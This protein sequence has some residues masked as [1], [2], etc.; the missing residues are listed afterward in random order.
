MIYYHKVIKIIKYGS[1][2]FILRVERNNIKF[3][4]GQFFSIGVPGVPIN[5]EYSVSSGIDE[6]Y[7]DFLIREINN[8][9]LSAKLKNLK[10]DDQIKIL[11]PY[12]EFYLKEFNTN[13]KYNFFASGSGLAP[14]IS[15]IRSF[16]NLNYNIFH[17]VRLFEDIYTENELKNYNVFIS[18]FNNKEKHSNIKT[19]NGRI[20]SNFEI[21]KNYINSKDFFFICGNSLMINDVYDYLE[22]NN[23]QNS[24]IYSE[25][26]F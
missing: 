8:G 19:Y 11:G 6:N 13:K 4:P 25:L 1:A 14:F 18:K 10:K 23:I 7:L 20:T 5:R 3:N 15:I 9:V 2:N 24:N 22:K 16:K 26:F 12:G 21:I 17:G